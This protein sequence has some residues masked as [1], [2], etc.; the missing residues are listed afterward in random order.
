MMSI[1]TPTPTPVPSSALKT[2]NTPNCSV[3]VNKTVSTTCSVYSYDFTTSSTTFLQNFN[4]ASPDI[5]HT[6]KKMWLYDTNP[7]IG[8]IYE[9]NI[10][11]SPWSATFNRTI[12]IPAFTDIGA[13]LGV[14]TSAATSITLVGSSGDVEPGEG[15]WIIKLD[16]SQL[17]RSGRFPDFFPRIRLINFLFWLNIN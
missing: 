8:K 5:A 10:T 15:E 11:L 2:L 7:T 13:G 3:L 9:Y 4:V 14:A 12:N 1:I 17:C 6:D 16:I